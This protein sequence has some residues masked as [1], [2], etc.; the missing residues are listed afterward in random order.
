MERE[1]IWEGHATYADPNRCES[2]GEVMAVGAWPF[3]PHPPPGKF[4]IVADDV[5]GGFIAENGF[6]EPR[7]FYSHSEHRAALAAEGV[8]IRAKWAGPGDKIMS[9]WAAGMD[10]GTL[11][12]A[13]T[14]L[15]RAEEARAAKR[16]M[17]TPI[18]VTD[19]GTFTGK[20]LES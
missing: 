6:A 14:R 3:C 8:E 19:A 7:K 1:R 17:T 11:E 2:C 9:N 15:G 20:D 16:A 12:N 13:R 18:T 5:P 4:N 10:A